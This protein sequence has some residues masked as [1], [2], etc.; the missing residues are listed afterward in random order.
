MTNILSLLDICKIE[1]FNSTQ[2]ANV[3]RKYD[4]SK[5]SV[6]IIDTSD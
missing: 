5:V 6:V 1:Y 4:Q 2:V 3:K